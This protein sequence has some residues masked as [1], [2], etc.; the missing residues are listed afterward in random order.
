MVSEVIVA[1]LITGGLGFLGIILTLF[2]GCAYKR[3]KNEAAQLR[4]ELS[5]T[6]VQLERLHSEAERYKAAYLGLL[7]MTQELLEEVS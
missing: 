1:A 6:R 5:T 2:Q 4:A 3:D 7:E